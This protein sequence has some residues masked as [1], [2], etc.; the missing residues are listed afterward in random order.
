[1]YVLVIIGGI[2]SLLIL[3]RGPSYSALVG[4]LPCKPPTFEFESVLYLCLW[5]ARLRNRH[6]AVSNP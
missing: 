4:A 5:D 6:S 1:M 3:N 2:N